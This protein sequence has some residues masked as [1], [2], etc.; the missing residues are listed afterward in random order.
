MRLE[1]RYRCAHTWSTPLPAYPADA[2]CGYVPSRIAPGIP[3]ITL[4]LV[5]L[6]ALRYGAE[7]LRGSTRSR[8]A[9]SA[10]GNPS[11]VRA[12]SCRRSGPPA[13]VLLD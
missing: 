9:R 7:A 6:A 3:S 1:D 5:T 8:P 12:R 11:N 13:N 2:T 4:D 10:C